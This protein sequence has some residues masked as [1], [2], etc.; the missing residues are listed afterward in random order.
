VRVRLGGSRRP[1]RRDLGAQPLQLLV[2]R[3]PVREQRRELLGALAQS[4]LNT[5]SVAVSLKLDSWISAERLS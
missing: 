1:R 4:G 3:V 2:E 5:A